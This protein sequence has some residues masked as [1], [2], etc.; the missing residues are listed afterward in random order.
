MSKP[1]YR[2]DTL[3]TIL[4]LILTPTTFGEGQAVDLALVSVEGLGIS[5]EAACK[6]ALRNALE[7]GAGVEISSHSQTDNFELIR[8]MVYSR[9]DGIVHDYKIVHQGRIA[10]GNYVCEITAKVSPSA[11]ASTWGEVQ[12]VLDQVGRP[13]IAVYILERI[14]GV[15]Q[16]SSILE[17][18]IENRLLKAG[19]DVYAG[20]QIRAI[21]DKEHLDAKAVGNVAKMQAIAKDFGTQIFITG[22]AQANA[23]GVKNLFG[24]QTARYN[25][26]GMIKMYYTDTG[27]LLASESLPSWRGGAPGFQTLSPQAGKKAL[28]NAG[29]ELVNRCY[30]SVMRQWATQISAGGMIELVIEGISAGQALKLKRKL[31][32][33]D[34]DRILSV[35]G[36]TLTKGI[37]TFQIK[38]K[39]SALTLADHLVEP[40]WEAIIEISDIKDNRIYATK[41][42][43]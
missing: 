11:V 6:D 13:G 17:S 32:T 39:M 35:N 5:Q 43:N 23:A 22:T 18:R 25:G 42:K 29:E 38:A 9:A 12:N 34:V 24:R 31:R 33:I 19:F 4:L 30:E 3:A 14:D 28:A 1:N 27:Q 40:D 26:D 8:D 2:L 37:A 20:E 16:D 36:P 7:K 15:I 21:A 10:G 41:V